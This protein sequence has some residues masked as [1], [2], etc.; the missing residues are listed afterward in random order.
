MADRQQLAQAMAR[1]TPPVQQQMRRSQYLTDALEALSAP[2]ENIRSPWELAARLAGVAIA[3]RGASKAQDKTAKLLKGEKDARL[4]RI[5][6]GLPGMEPEQP[7]APQMP[8]M[9]AAPPMAPA[10]PPQMQQPA[11]IATAPTPPAQPNADGQLF[12]IT[13]QSESRNRDLNPDGSVVTSPAGARGRMQVMDGTNRD[14]GFGVRPAQDDGLEERARV[15]RDYLLAM[16]ERYGGD[17][18]KAW[19][20]YNWGPG[21]LDAA[22]NAHGENWL[23]RAPSETQAYVT[24]NLRALGQQ[25]PQMAQAPDAQVQGS[26]FTAQLMAAGA[27]VDP[28]APSASGSSPPA[29]GAPPA[30]TPQAAA[31]GNPTTFKPTREEVS[32]I[33]QLLRS[34]DPSQ[35]ALGEELAN[36]LRYKM[37]QADEWETT[38]VN[39]V[40]AQVHPRTGEVRMLGV[41]EGARTQTVQNVPGLTPGTV[42]QQKP[43][44]EVSVLQA[45]PAGFQGAP[46]R[47]TFTPGGPQDPAAGGNLVANEGKLRDDYEKQIKDYSLAREGYQK[48]VAAA[49]GNT[50][51]DSIAMIFGVMKTLDPTSTVREGEYATVQNSGTV[52]QTVANL[53]NRLLAGG[54][55]L[56]QKQRSQFSDMARRQFDVYQKTADQLNERYGS[57][58]K[59]YGYA[60]E[61]IVRD[62]PVIE[63]YAAPSGPAAGQVQFPAAVNQAHQN[64]VARGQYDPKAPLGSEKRPFLAADDAAVAAVDKPAN[65]GK[66]IVLPNGDLARID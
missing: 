34:G 63:P 48:V 61:R 28:L 24:A 54:A 56:T 29:A 15:G 23:S 25:S 16:R 2:Q 64:M 4:A 3:K 12:A 7:P 59:S 19:G 27:G 36:K 65:K 45:P 21:N 32:Y 53:Y 51:A 20:A 47:Q 46:D 62:F 30:A 31:G 58:A 66:F 13:A 22:L 44:G 60:P 8:A 55:P 42:A 52:D 50:A 43:T 26:D 6:A 35:E 11:P 5:L 49:K 9:P 41:P 1:Y 33:T 18:A 14:P 40:P 57:L 38:T 39:G 10:A 37:T 17:M